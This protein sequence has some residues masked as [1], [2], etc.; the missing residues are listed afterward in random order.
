MATKAKQAP[1]EPRLFEGIPR[2]VWGGFNSGVLEMQYYDRERKTP[3]ED[4]L[5]GSVSKPVHQVDIIIPG[6]AK[7]PVGKVTR[8]QVSTASVDDETGG[9]NVTYFLKGG[10]TKTVM[11]PKR[12]KFRLIRR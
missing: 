8:Y 12:E 9:V 1:S 5:A 6:T 11:V 10:K 4:R 3:A 7:N 2:A